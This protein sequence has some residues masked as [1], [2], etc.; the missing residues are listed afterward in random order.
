L[1]F[2]TR[3]DATTIRS[4]SQLATMVKEQCSLSPEQAEVDVREWAAGK[5]F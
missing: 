2:L 1:P 5:R 3:F 4:A